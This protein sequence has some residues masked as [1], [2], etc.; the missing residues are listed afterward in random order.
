MIEK[1]QNNIEQ[2]S[3]IKVNKIYFVIH[4]GFCLDDS[5]IMPTREI[6]EKFLELL[7]KYETYLLALPKNEIAVIFEPSNILFPKWR[8]YKKERAN[9]SE[10]RWMHLVDALQQKLGRRLIV[11]KDEGMIGHYDASPRNLKN[12][13]KNIAVARGFKISKE[14]AKLC[15]G[16]CA[17]V[18]VQNAARGLA[19]WFGE[20]KPIPINEELTDESVWQSLEKN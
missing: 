7:K 10:K 15:F 16:E 18:C 19:E 11:L 6:T 5:W 9:I 1:Y 17:V 20:T 3:L 14:T 4:P 13:I 12:I 2:E 8:Q